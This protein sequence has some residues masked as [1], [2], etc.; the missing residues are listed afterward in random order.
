MQPAE[1][2]G[3]NSHNQRVTGAPALDLFHALEYTFFGAYGSCLRRPHTGTGS[4]RYL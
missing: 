4:C 1:L 3:G 2:Y